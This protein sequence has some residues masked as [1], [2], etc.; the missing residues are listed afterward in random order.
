MKTVRKLLLKLLDVRAEIFM[1]E[2]CVVVSSI[3]I[4]KDPEDEDTKLG[5]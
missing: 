3:Y 4:N 2:T 5:D 1:K